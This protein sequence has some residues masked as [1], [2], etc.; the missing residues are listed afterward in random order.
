MKR[1]GKKTLE[2][3]MRIRYSGTNR[4]YGTAPEVINEKHGEKIGYITYD[5][6]M[7]MCR[8]KT[9]VKDFGDYWYSEYIVE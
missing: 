8:V 4:I 7:E 2:K 6:F 5:L 9:L 3:G 1:Y